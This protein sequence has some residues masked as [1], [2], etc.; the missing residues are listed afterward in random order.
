MSN[1]NISLSFQGLAGD[2]RYEDDLTQG[3]ID[4]LF[5][6]WHERFQSVQDN[7]YFEGSSGGWEARQTLLARDRMAVLKSFVSED[8]YE[9]ASKEEDLRTLERQMFG[10]DGLYEQGLIDEESPIGQGGEAITL[11]SEISVKNITCLTRFADKVRAYFDWV[12]EPSVSERDSSVIIEGKLRLHRFQCLNGLALG[13]S[14]LAWI[15]N[16]GFCRVNLEASIDNGSD[17]YLFEFDDKVYSYLNPP[18]RGDSEVTI[19]GRR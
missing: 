10:V 7:F 13:I 12:Q 15:M 5:L 6:H 4:A 9:S 8:V 3:E 18:E 16:G 17:S 1:L 11:R 2:T 14:S 19:H